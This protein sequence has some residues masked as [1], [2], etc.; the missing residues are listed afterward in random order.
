MNGILK[1]IGGGVGKFLTVK[2]IV[3]LVVVVVLGG[4]IYMYKGIAVAALVDWR[5]ISRVAVIKQLEK[6][7]GKQA[8]DALIVEKLVQSELKKAG[9]LVTDEEVS[10][11]IKKIE[12][13]IA[14]Q[15]GTLDQLL[16]MEGVTKDELKKQL[17]TQIQVKKFF[18]DK[19][20]VADEEVSKYIKDN[21]ITV[22]KEGG[23]EFK[24][25]IKEQLEGQKLNQAAGEWVETLRSKASIRYFVNY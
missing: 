7:S 15:G 23:E 3:I 13:T 1:K 22:P 4:L 16:E 6:N 24:K 5:P 11:E 12:E 25:Q 19:T 21:K 17:R 8:L 10:A 14:A 2:N 20:A 9:T 18:A